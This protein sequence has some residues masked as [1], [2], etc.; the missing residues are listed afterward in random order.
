MEI[1]RM[2]ARHW[3]LWWMFLFVGIVGCGGSNQPSTT[4]TGD[5]PQSQATEAAAGG[6]ADLNQTLAAT[7]SDP[8]S[9]VATFLDAVRR[10]DDEKTAAMFTPVAFEKV[11][12]LGIQ[13]AP[14]GSDTAKFEIG[15]V[16]KLADDGARVESMWSD[17]DPEGKE[18]SEQIT[19]MVRKEKFGWRVAGMAVPAFPGE[20]PVLLDLEKPEEAFKKLELL[21]KEYQRRTEAATQQAQRPE[22]TEKSVQR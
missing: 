9:A 5:K 15:K 4:P 22:E 7:T 13:V 3:M 1:D 14:R 21:E 10:G 2:Q 8:A 16:E 18:H 12:A 20:P 11:N 17:V 6:Q 19:L